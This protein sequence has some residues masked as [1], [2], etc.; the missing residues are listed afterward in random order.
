MMNARNEEIE[1]PLR[2]PGVGCPPWCD[3]ALWTNVAVREGSLW[4][5]GAPHVV[6]GFY[7]VEPT[8]LTVQA[9]WVEKPAVHRRQRRPRVRGA[10]GVGR[11]GR[12]RPHPFPS[13][14]VRRRLVAVADS[15][16][17]KPDQVTT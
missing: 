5:H 12:T 11:G 14:Q 8:A 7:N 4:H 3:P 15:L 17:A 10:A 1:L 2:T 13:T 16:E 9:T 6:D